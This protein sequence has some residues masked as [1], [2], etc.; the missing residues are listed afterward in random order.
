MI[1]KALFILLFVYNYNASP[2]HFKI[3]PTDM[4]FHKYIAYE[5]KEIS[6]KIP[7]DY[8]RYF[9]EQTLEIIKGDTKELT[10]F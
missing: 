7:L 3:K 10:W 5:G 9:L 2:S 4:N 1:P 8:K 6:P